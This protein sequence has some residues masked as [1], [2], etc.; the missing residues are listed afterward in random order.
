M[1]NNKVDKRYGHKVSIVV[2]DTK[3]DGKDII[4]LDVIIDG[5]SIGENE[6]NYEEMYDSYEKVPQSLRFVQ[7]VMAAIG[8]Q[9]V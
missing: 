7:T 4:M 8:G 2:E 1:I 3:E 5:K 6:V 9:I